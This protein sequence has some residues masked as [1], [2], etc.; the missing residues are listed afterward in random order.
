MTTLRL[1][2]DLEDAIRSL[3]GVQAVSIVTTGDGAP[4]EVHVL[5]A[6]GKPAKQIVRDVQSLAMTGFDL[7]IDHRIVSVVQIGTPPVDVDEEAPQDPSDEEDTANGRPVIT[8][9]SMLTARHESTAT[10]TIQAGDEQYEG[11]ARGSSGT[12]GRP[13]LVAMATLTALESLLGLPCEVETAA[14][15]D[16]GSHEVAL[17]VLNLTAARFGQQVLAGSA[18]VRSDATDGVARAVLAALNRQLAG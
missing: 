9:V 5:A 2:Q 14:V 17:V 3:P 16:A 13:R 10:V 15:V 8:S 11:T 1:L 7:E 18:I 12:S 6:P 4:T